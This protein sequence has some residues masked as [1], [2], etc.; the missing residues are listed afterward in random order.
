[1]VIKMQ[2]FQHRQACLQR[3][4]SVSQLAQLNILGFESGG[5]FPS[6]MQQRVRNPPEAVVTGDDQ[7]SDVDSSRSQARAWL[8]RRWVVRKEMPSSSAASSWL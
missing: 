4:V 3:S 7:G 6:F 8:Q 1:M 2:C 5:S